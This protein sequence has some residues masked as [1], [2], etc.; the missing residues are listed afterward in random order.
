M[1][2]DL[3]SY[4][5]GRMA[6]VSYFDTARRLASFLAKKARFV[7]TSK[8]RSCHKARSP[9]WSLVDTTRVKPYVNR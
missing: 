1:H 3:V 8:V 5:G 4:F 9:M 2:G 7:T 6:L